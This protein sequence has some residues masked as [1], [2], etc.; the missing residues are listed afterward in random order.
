MSRTANIHTTLLSKSKEKVKLNCF[1]EKVGTEIKVLNCFVA[2]PKHL[3]P[4]TFEELFGLSESQ[5]H[6]F[7]IKAATRKKIFDNEIPF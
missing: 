7:V 2:E 5:V 4:F 3:K 1:L 6:D